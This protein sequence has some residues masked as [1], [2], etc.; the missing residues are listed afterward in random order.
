MSLN[1]QISLTRI[2]SSLRNFKRKSDTL[3]NCS[4]PVCGDSETDKHKARGYF[5]DSS[6]GMA[7][8]CHNCHHSSSFRNFLRTYYPSEWK[9]YSVE[10]YK[11][12]RIKDTEKA[13]DSSPKNLIEN[14]HSIE[15][16]QKANDG[17]LYEL[18]D[19]V[20]TLDPSHMARLY[21]ASRGIPDNLNKNFYH[22]DDIR[23]IENLKT[24]IESV[25]PRLVI[26]FRN[27]QGQVTGLLLRSYNRLV[28]KKYIIHRLK[29]NVEL[30]YG[31]D[32]LD[33]NKKFVF[34]TEGPIDSMFIDNAVAVGGSSFG[35][36]LKA[37]PMDRTISV[38]DNQPRNPEVVDEYMKLMRMGY[39]VFVWPD[40]IPS[41][42]INDAVKNGEL[43]I[44]NLTNFVI[45]NSFSKLELLL[46][47]N[48]WKRI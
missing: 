1:D 47:I 29:E 23:D 15:D 36:L 3:W 31:L 44:D 2:S 14:L 27:R 34:L 43:S 5:I 22:I 45:E 28:K 25:E 9:N 37:F 38:L 33:L 21:L 10:E 46:K 24:D 42:D 19:R 39:R 30:F 48:Q 16:L 11:V 6:D 12:N 4:C 20:D 41:K 18:M 40:N 26:P 8:Y 13:K 32:K 35:R 7:Y 17:L